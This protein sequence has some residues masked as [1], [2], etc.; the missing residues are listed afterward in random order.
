ML[1][2]KC[3]VVLYMADILTD[4][5][6]PDLEQDPWNDLYKPISQNIIDNTFYTA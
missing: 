3:E 1:Y 2:G 5:Y 4:G 6:L